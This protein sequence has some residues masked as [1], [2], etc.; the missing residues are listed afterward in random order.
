MNHN[1]TGLLIPIKDTKSLYSAIKG[2]NKDNYKFYSDN[3]FKEFDKFDSSKV[4]PKLFKNIGL[5]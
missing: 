2:I 5:F 1:K 4:Y 3:A